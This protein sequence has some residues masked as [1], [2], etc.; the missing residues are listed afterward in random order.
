MADEGIDFIA[1]RMASIVAERIKCRPAT[2]E[3]LWRDGLETMKSGVSPADGVL[4]PKLL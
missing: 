2:G 3:F 4:A 1:R